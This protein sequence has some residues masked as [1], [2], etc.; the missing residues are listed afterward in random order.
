MGLP[1]RSDSRQKENRINAG[2]TALTKP[3]P[4]DN[5]SENEADS[6]TK[7]HRREKHGV[8]IWNNP[9]VTWS[10][11]VDEGIK[12]AFKP[13]AK[14]VFGSICL[15]IE[16]ICAGLMSAHTQ[17]EEAGVHLGQTVDIDVATI[18]IQRGLRPRRRLEVDVCGFKG[19][20]EHAMKVGTWRGNRRFP[21]CQQHVAEAE[22]KPD[23]W[24]IF[25]R[26]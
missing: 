4:E 18:N 16:C 26:D 3:G 7:V 25:S 15:P 6:S 24:E 19:C 5:S 21:L 1:R 13:Y 14:R 20:N 10:I 2:E 17:A 23:E 12:K 22:R 11:R 8:G 9:R